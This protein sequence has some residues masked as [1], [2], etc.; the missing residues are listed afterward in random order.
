MELYIKGQLKC[1]LCEMKNILDKINGRS[2]Q[3]KRLMNLKS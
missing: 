1:T 3:K 2:V